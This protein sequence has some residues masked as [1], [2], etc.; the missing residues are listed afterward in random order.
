MT[1]F[2]SA[3]AVALVIGASGG[4]AHA[5]GN[6]VLSSNALNPT[7]LSD[8]GSLNGVAVEGVALPPSVDR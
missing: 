2:A 5:G 6:D 3:F 4:L 8:V 1:R 7:G